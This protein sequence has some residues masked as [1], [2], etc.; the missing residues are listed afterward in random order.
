MSQFYLN[1][2]TEWLQIFSYSSLRDNVKWRQLNF[3]SNGYLFFPSIRSVPRRVSTE[4]KNVLFLYNINRCFDFFF[5]SVTYLFIL[6][7]RLMELWIV[8]ELSTFFIKHININSINL[9]FIYNKFICII[10]IDFVP[11][12]VTKKGH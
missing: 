7:P 2:K 10:N 8:L 6:V 3:F 4:N 5:I 9:K 12:Y 1:Y 11:P